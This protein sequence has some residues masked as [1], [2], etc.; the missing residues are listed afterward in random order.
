[1]E[2]LPHQAELQP[3]AYA[4]RQS[5][6]TLRVGRHLL[7]LYARYPIHEECRRVAL[8]LGSN[9]VARP[10]IELMLRVGA[11]KS[12]GGNVV[13]GP[14][15]AKSLVEPGVGAGECPARQRV[16]VGRPLGSERPG[17]IRAGWAFR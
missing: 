4:V 11:V 6:V 3:V 14:G 17:G 2:V 10:Q 5:G 12:A 8:Q 7:P 1:P 15:R 9:V 16:P 13:A